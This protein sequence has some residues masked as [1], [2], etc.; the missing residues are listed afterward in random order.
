M[1]VAQFIFFWGGPPNGI[2]RVCNVSWWPSILRGDKPITNTICLRQEGGWSLI[3]Q[4]GTWCDGGLW[5]AIL[6]SRLRFPC[7]FLQ[8]IRK[9]LGSEKL[10]CDFWEIFEWILLG[11]RQKVIGFPYSVLQ[12]QKLLV[13]G[14][15]ILHQ[16]TQIYQLFGNGIERKWPAN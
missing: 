2:K 5:S 10:V 15:L 6:G 13:F 14:N 12:F 3:R 1:C 11:L 9:V 7:Q 4:I 8:Y 16:R